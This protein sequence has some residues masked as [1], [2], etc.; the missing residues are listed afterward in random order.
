MLS[1]HGR[2][3]ALNVKHAF[4]AIVLGGI[5]LASAP[6]IACSTDSGGGLDGGANTDA[7][8]FADEGELYDT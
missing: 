1:R 8:Q 4:Q 7:M 6:E 5:A 3:I 2:A